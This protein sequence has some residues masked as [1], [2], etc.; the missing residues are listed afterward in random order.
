[1]PKGRPHLLMLT[2]YSIN[3]LTVA[4]RMIEAP[5]GRFRQLL[6]DRVDETNA[7]RSAIATQQVA[8]H[9]SLQQ[10]PIGVIVR[11]P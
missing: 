9:R 7:I 11:R 8:A 6:A 5:S 3:D 4:T 10:I 2:A 1:M